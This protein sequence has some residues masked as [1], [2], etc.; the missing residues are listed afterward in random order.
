MGKGSRVKLS[1]AMVEQ[2]APRAARHILWDSVVPGFALRIEPSGIK[3]Y[4]VRYRADGGGRAAPQRLVTIGRHGLYTVDQA[5]QRARII[6]GEAAI[7]DD[8]AKRKAQR[9]RELSITDLG[10]SL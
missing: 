8:P 1:K 6:L 3:T 2:A 7:G 5:R 10:R 9:R 4:F